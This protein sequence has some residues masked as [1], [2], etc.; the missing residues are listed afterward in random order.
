MNTLVIVL[1]AVLGQA[2]ERSDPLWRQSYTQAENMAAQIKRPVA[3]FLTQGQNS[4]DRLIPGGLNEQAKEILTS[5]YIPVMVDTSTPEGQ[6][7]ARAFQIRDGLGLVLSDR[8]G[9]YQAFWHQGSLTNEELVRKLQKY[10]NQTNVRMTEAD[11][12]SSLYPPEEQGAPR[13]RLNRRGV[14]SSTTTAE[15]QRRVRLFQG[16][17]SRRSASY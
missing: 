14:E 17:L 11:G 8:G 15:S 10:A 13:R 9:A 7:L 6:R 2:E 3:V 5:D 4:I 1:S 16:R 12:R